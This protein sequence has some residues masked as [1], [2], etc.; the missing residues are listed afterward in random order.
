MELMYVKKLMLK[1]EQ[2]EV[3]QKI[4]KIVEDHE[5]TL[6]NLK[7]VVED[8]GEYMADNALLIPEK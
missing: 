2:Q 7:E 3:F 1:A 4:L 5:L 6:T 8:V